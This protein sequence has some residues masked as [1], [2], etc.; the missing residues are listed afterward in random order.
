LLASQLG[1]QGV[2]T[3]AEQTEAVVI[4]QDLLTSD[5]GFS[6]ARTSLARVLIN[7]GQLVEAEKELERVEQTLSGFN[8]EEVLGFYYARIL[9][10]KEQDNYSQALEIT[11]CILEIEPQDDFALSLV[12]HFEPLVKSGGMAGLIEEQREKARHHSWQRWGRV[13]R[14]DIS[15]KELVELFNKE[16]LGAILTEWKQPFDKHKGSKA[17]YLSQ[18]QQVLSPQHLEQLKDAR[19]GLGLDENFIDEEA[20]HALLR[21]LKL[22]GY[23]PYSVWQAAAGFED[24][25]RA[26]Q[27]LRL[28]RL[29]LWERLPGRLQARG[30]VY[31]GEVEGEGLIALVPA[32]LRKV[33]SQLL[34]SPISENIR[35]R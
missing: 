15:I 16:E 24:G 2:T 33:L 10:Y 23:T 9:L 31:L 34:E 25:L 28:S 29:S 7:Q 1:E 35:D 26:E 13:L 5:P 21:L 27:Y 32:D 4:L 18:V 30:L 14:P 3:A 12:E 11:R 6:A 22:G 8:L 19:A 17:S 20:R